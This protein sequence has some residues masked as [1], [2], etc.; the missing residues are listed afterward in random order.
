[1][2]NKIVRNPGWAM[3]VLIVHAFM[4]V[5]AWI[6][7]HDIEKLAITWGVP[8][9]IAWTA[10]L[11]IDGLMW[12]G[13]L[14]RSEKFEESTRKAGLFLMSGGGAASMVAN[15]AAGENVG[16][17]VYGAL[18]VI[19]YVVAEWYSGKLKPLAAVAVELGTGT[20]ATVKVTEAEKAARKRAG[21]DKMDAKAK[22][23]W[24]TDYRTRQ[25]R[26]AKKATPAPA[27]A[28]QLQ[29]TTV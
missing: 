19:G 10:P 21:Y 3:T 11:F 29:S 18:V 12:M 23:R 1:M 13:K 27:P 20:K 26:A 15:V 25:A 6:S 14:G 17:R 2:F 22:A 5:A 24:T 4:G 7:F 28:A 9:G 8:T 16:M